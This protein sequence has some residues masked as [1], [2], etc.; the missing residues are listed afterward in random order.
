MRVNLIVQPV[1]RH[2]GHTN[3][4]PLSMTFGERYVKCRCFKA[5]VVSEAASTDPGA[6]QAVRFCGR[7]IGS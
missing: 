4:V 2:K 1:A 7:A 3:G 6:S 5:C